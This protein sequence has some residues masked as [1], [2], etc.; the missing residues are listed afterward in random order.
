[1]RFQQYISAV[2]CII[3]ISAIGRSQDAVHNYGNIKVHDQGLVGF[4]MDV[5]NDGAFNQNLGL[6]GFYCQNKPLTLSGNSNP[7]FYDTEIAVDEGFYVDNT[8]GVLNNLNLISGDIIT[9]RS[10]SDININFQNQSF[11]IGEGDATKVDG[12]A[13]IS[14]KDFFTFPVGQNDRI[15]PLTIVSNSS[16]DYAKCA[17]FYEDPNTPSIFGTSFNTETLEDE[18]LSVST[19]EFWHL[20][21]AIPSKVT[22]SWDGNSNIMLLAE[23]ITDLKVVGW[24]ALRKEW[25]NLGNTDVQGDMENGTIT[26]GEFVPSDYQII[27][28]G[29]NN[30][31]LET[32]DNIQLDNYYMTPNGDGVNDS[33]VIEGIENSP[34]NSIQ[35]FNRYGILVYSQQN[36]QN[37][38][39]GIS[40]RESVLSRNQGL[41]SG[42]YFYI[43]TL[44]D[45]KLRHQGYLY[46]STYQDK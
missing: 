26:S 16:N 24:S 33:L 31:L 35:I 39:T 19:Y 1:M 6:V 17:Y 40:N 15:R 22:L 11:Y 27:T 37:D 42:I 14:N 10:K 30:D 20:D 28:L 5:I 23:F 45:L 8:V 4:H 9:S 3:V 12:Y 44:N 18:F 29:G 13:A 21:S 34:N 2:I 32:L 38:F 36:Y 46:L 41:A 7:V 25:V 43:I